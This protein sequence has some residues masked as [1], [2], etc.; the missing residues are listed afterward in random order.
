MLGTGDKGTIPGWL[1]LDRPTQENGK[2]ASEELRSVWCQTLS[3]A[4]L[5][6][7]QPSVIGGAFLGNGTPSRDTGTCSRLWVG[8]GGLR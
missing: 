7:K 8:P 6:L 5:V 3:G 2:V 4:L 1:A